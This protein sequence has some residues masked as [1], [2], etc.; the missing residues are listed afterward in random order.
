VGYVGKY[1]EFL[2]ESA[3]YEVDLPKALAD[4][5][6]ERVGKDHRISTLM[7][8]SHEDKFDEMWP[9]DRVFNSARQLEADPVIKGTHSEDRIEQARLQILGL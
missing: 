4:I 1:D 7:A 2:T 9:K 3:R 6:R 5:M 8:V